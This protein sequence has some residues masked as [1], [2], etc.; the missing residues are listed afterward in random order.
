MPLSLL[1]CHIRLCQQK[2]N[3]VLFSPRHI[4]CRRV[5]FR[6]ISDVAESSSAP[7]QM[8]QSL[9]PR[10]IRCRL[11]CFPAISDTA[12]KNKSARK[13]Y[14]NLDIFFKIYKEFFKKYFTTDQS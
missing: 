3:L 6:A 4:R 14:Q 2:I 5:C 11:V 1:P 9:L 7:Y 10:H 8:L 12:E 13:K